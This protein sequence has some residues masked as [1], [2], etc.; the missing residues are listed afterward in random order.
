[1]ILP[2]SAVLQMAAPPSADSAAAKGVQLPPAWHS[3]ACPVSDGG[4]DIVVCGKRDA[5]EKY[6]LRP[7]PEKYAPIGGPGIGVDLGNG[8]R[9]NLH[10]EQGRPGDKRVMVTVTMPF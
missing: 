4:S 8:A 5:A 6:R 3:S 10:T 1:M 7:L 9:G 2:I